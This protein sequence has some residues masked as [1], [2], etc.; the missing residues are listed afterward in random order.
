MNGMMGNGSYIGQGSGQRAV[1][2]EDNGSV[3]DSSIYHADAVSLRQQLQQHQLQSP[4]SYH[5]QQLPLHLSSQISLSSDTA[6]NT[7]MP[8]GRQSRDAS[9][10]DHVAKAD[11]SMEDIMRFFLK[12]GCDCLTNAC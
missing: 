4:E 2:P 5:V 11:E 3:M 10:A 9:V 12:V 1:S 7:C 8:A 6:Q